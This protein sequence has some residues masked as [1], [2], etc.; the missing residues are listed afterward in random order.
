MRL[1]K[2]WWARP[3]LEKSPLVIVEPKQLKNKWSNEFKNNNDI[4]LELGCGRGKFISEQA[5]LNPDKNFV[6]I[7]LKDEVLIYALR[8]VQEKN[9]TN[10][11]IV[12]LEIA[13]ISEVF[14]SNEIGQIF[15]NF[16]NPWPKERHKKRRLTHTK[17]LTKYKG[18][19]NPGT[20]IWFKTDDIF[21]FEES[22]K[23]FKESGFDIIY[24]SYDLHNSG[25]DKNIKTEY[26]SKFTTLGI[27][28]KF[29]IAKL[30]R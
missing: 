1:R 19:I 24:I 9:L 16:C 20:E 10:V 25:F 13:F 27:N 21:L 18:F 5:S 3:D 14:G 11:R 15:I 29:M 4:Y 28:T 17:F 8:N 30:R 12:P 22:K 26:E 23:Y 2:K 6:A 7:D